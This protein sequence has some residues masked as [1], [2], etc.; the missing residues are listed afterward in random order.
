MVELPSIELEDSLTIVAIMAEKND[1]RFQRAAVRW[2]GRLCTERRMSLAE[3][4]QAVEL[5]ETCPTAPDEV[6]EALLRYCLRLAIAPA[7]Q[8]A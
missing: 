1:R 2:L 3:L 6:E 8:R 7:G 5:L 4:R